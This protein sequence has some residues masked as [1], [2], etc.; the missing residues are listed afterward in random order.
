MCTGRVDLAFIFRSLLNKKDGVLIGGCYPGECHYLTQGNFGAISTFHIGRKLFELVGLNPE[1]LRLE[2]ISA[3]EGNRY[4]QVTN[5]FSTKV[6]ELGPLGEGEGIDKTVLRQKLEVVYN[7]V[8]YIK[9][10]E[11]ERLRQSVKTVEAYNAFF[12][13]DEFDKIFQDLIADKME[14][15]QIMEILRKKPCSSR[16]I[17]ELLNITVSKAA[18]QLK[19]S[20]RQGFIEFDESQMRFCVI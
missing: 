11:R 12:A 20:A 15:S 4:A 17:S 19:L 13:S 18:N 6:K 5:D 9:L 8:P 7:L 2:H 16:E 1:R 10:V 14:L 3:S